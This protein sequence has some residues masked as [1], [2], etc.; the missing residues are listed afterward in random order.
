MNLTLQKLKS[1]SILL[2]VPSMG[3]WH[4]EFGKSLS[5]LTTYFQNTKIGQFKSQ[6]LHVMSMRGSILPNLRLTALLAAREKNVDYMLWVD[7]DQSF[8]RETLHWLIGR[9][10]D[11]VG[12]NIATKTMPTLPTARRKPVPGEPAFGALVYTD[13]DSRGVEQVWRIGCGLTLMSRKVIQALPNDCFTMRYKPDVQRYQGEDWEMC[14]AIE[15]LGFEIYID[16][17]LS[18]RVGHHGGF[19]YTHEYNGEVV[20]EELK[21][22]RKEEVV[23]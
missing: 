16:H 14:E 7:S 18:K 3:S 2:A 11:V 23:G 15:R 12:A 5:N 9:Q 22:G 19:N 10:L 8:P 17:E 21:H 6:Q 20:R 1:L 4:E 13:E